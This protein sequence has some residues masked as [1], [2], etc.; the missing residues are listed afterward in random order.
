MDAGTGLPELFPCLA[1]RTP[2]PA[3]GRVMWAPRVTCALT[4]PGAHP[5]LA[6]GSRLAGKARPEEGVLALGCLEERNGHRMDS[7]RGLPRW[8]GSSLW[9]HPPLASDWGGG[10]VY[11]SRGWMEKRRPATQMSFSKLEGGDGD[12]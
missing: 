5:E 8:S 1:A 2:S 4:N 9:L 6:R 10:V 11:L 3:H 12:I 7:T